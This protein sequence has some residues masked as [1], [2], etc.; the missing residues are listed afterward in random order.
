MS[1][2]TVKSDMVPNTKDEERVYEHDFG[3]PDCSNCQ[4]G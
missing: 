2:N 1:N 4:K 3:K